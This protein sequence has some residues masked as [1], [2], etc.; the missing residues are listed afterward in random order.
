MSR[1]EIV[2][3]TGIQFQHNILRKNTLNLNE[4]L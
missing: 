2:F 3:V 1:I 4:F